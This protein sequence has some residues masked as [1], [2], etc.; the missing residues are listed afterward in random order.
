MNEH[1][2]HDTVESTDGTP[3]EDVA[4]D[5]V[6]IGQGGAQT[7]TGDRVEITQGGA[8]KVQAEH[9]TVTQGG[10]GMLIAEHAELHDQSNVGFA[11][12]KEAKADEFKVG[13][14]AAGHVE[15]EVHAGLEARTAAI[16]AAVF[17]ATL[18]LLKRLFSR[19]G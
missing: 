4:A 10:I 17:A 16:A 9:V 8:G 6:E 19:G 1:D 18:F 15:G 12:I 13:F 2:E 14:L 7:V 5:H 3:I 11:I